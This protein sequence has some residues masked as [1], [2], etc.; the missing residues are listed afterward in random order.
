MKFHTKIL[1]L[2][3]ICILQLVFSQTVLK[4]NINKK[5]QYDFYSNEYLYLVLDRTDS[6]YQIISLPPLEGGDV[7]QDTF[8]KGKYIIKKC[9]IIFTAENIDDH[10]PNF[11]KDISGLKFKIYKKYLV[12]KSDKNKYFPYAEKL[13]LSNLKEYKNLFQEY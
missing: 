8:S 9:S 6:T 11:F 1:L 3:K 7:K 10:N 5:H 13:Q 2:A 4:F 12:P